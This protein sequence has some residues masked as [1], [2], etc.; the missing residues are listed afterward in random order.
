MKL[1]ILCYIAINLFTYSSSSIC[2]IKSNK[3]I[4][5]TTE[6]DFPD[7][8]CCFFNDQCIETSLEQYI[9]GTNKIFKAIRREMSG[10]YARESESEFF[11]GECKDA[12]ISWTKED[13]E[14]TNDDTALLNSNNHCLKYHDKVIK[15]EITIK[16]KETC[17]KADILESS[18]NAGME[19]AFYQLEILSE[20]YGSKKVNTCFLFDTNIMKTITNATEIDYV[21]NFT[22][23]NVINNFA[24]GIENP[25][26]SINID[27]SFG[28]LSYDSKSGINSFRTSFS[29]IIIFSKFL[30]LFKT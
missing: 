30:Y 21:T 8:Q 25:S 26:Y 24:I 22:F 15:N 17:L 18:K 20:S 10:F 3:D 6:L 5:L 19:C 23:N 9:L 28:S 12:N 1:F 2:Y 13:L 11:N 7:K 4:C 27:S 16:S 14:F 29:K